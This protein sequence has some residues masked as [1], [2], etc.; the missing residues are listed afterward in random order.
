[1]VRGIPEKSFGKIPKYLHMLREANPGTHTFYETDVDGRFR[2]LF[3]SFGRSV[4]GFQTAMRQV[5][6]VDGTFLKSKY[7]GVLLVATAL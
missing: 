3:V 4:Q 6:V 5:L 2:F 1:M 7:K